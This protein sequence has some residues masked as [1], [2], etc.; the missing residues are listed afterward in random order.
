MEA[1]GPMRAVMGVLYDAGWFPLHPT[2]GK[3]AGEDVVNWSFAGVGDS[4]KMI[5]VLSRDIL[6]VHWAVRLPTGMWRVWR[7]VVTF[8]SESS[9]C[10]FS[11]N[12][13]TRG[14][15]PAE[16]MEV[17]AAWDVVEP[18]VKH[19]SCDTLKEWAKSF[20]LITL[21]DGTEGPFSSDPVLLR[22]RWGAAIQDF[23]DVFA[24]SVVSPAPTQT[25]PRS[26]IYA[27]IQALRLAPRKTHLVLVSDTLRP[28]EGGR[29]PWSS[30][31]IFLAPGVH[32]WECIRRMRLWLGAGLDPSSAPSACRFA[33]RSI[34]VSGCQ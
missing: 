30:A 20:R 12:V 14:M 6:A 5:Q 17:P 7:K 23:T 2:N 1:R 24:P 21:L 22:C 4:A 32:H 26:E 3:R 8:P 16:W 34:C 29:S 18:C 28:R 9:I 19:N 13:R 27:G 25:V 10:D 11:R 31:V 15:V 33:A